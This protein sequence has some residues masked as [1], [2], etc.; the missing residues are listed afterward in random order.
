M[1]IHLKNIEGNKIRAVFQ[2]RNIV[3]PKLTVSQIEDHWKKSASAGK[4]LFRGEVFCVE[5]IQEEKNGN[6]TI[7]LTKSDYVHYLATIDKIISEKQ[8]CKSLYTSILLT[9][10][11]NYL[12]FGKKAG[13]TSSPGQLECAGGGVSE[14]YIKTDGVISLLE[15]TE[16]ELGE[17]LYLNPKNIKHITEPLS[18]RFLK[19]GGD[20][21]TVGVF[22]ETQTSFVR[23]EFE[24]FFSVGRE[25]EIAL[26][27]HPEFESVVFIERT[28]EGARSFL[29]Q[30]MKINDYMKAVLEEIVKLG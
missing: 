9:T 3:L 22:F 1:H 24:E 14:K 11:D 5:D 29:E 27:K 12:V 18:P 8:Y 19:T 2:N 13:S 7:F 16:N 28:K 21:G 4:N 20:F 6:T 30:N 23:S 15:N 25:K 17:E 26:G 10:K